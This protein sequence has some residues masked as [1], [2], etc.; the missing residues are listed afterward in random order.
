MRKL[1]VVMLGSGVG[2]GED[3]SETGISKSCVPT[4]YGPV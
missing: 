3:N 1:M 4:L 2:E